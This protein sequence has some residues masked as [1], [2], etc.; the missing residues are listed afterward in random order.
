MLHWMLMAPCLKI[1]APST[2]NAASSAAQHNALDLD[3]S[4]AA[5]HPPTPLAGCLALCA[6]LHPLEQH[7]D[8]MVH[9]AERLE[10]LA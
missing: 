6:D 4:M 9:L 2:S 5:V 8:A 7:L 1:E 3:L 10:Q